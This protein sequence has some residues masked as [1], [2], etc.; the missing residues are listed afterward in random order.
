M[1]APNEANFGSTEGV[2]IKG[3]GTGPAQTVLN[4]VIESFP[5]NVIFENLT[6]SGK[7]HSSPVYYTDSDKSI[8]FRKCVFITG[9]SPWFKTAVYSL[10]GRL[11][12]IDSTIINDSTTAAD[13]DI[14]IWVDSGKSHRMGLMRSKIINFPIGL[15]GGSWEKDEQRDSIQVHKTKLSTNQVECCVE[16]DYVNSVRTCVDAS[17]PLQNQNLNTPAGSVSIRENI[18]LVGEYDYT[19]DRY[20]PFKIYFPEVLTKGHTFTYKLFSAHPALPAHN[21]NQ[22]HPGNAEP[23]YFQFDSSAKL[24][25]KKVKIMFEKSVIDSKFANSMN[26]KAFLSFN[27]EKW[28]KKPLKL[29]VVVQNGV[30]F[31]QARYPKRNYLKGLIAFGEIQNDD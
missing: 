26:I 9:V 7:Q 5:V 27:G 23:Q 20:L 19:T 12:F 10:S 6:F 4:T 1:N 31:Y 30:N 17:C 21:N 3:T 8:L 28:K 13:A 29:K 24:S 16:Y 2:L 22:Y 15:Y 18:D 11:T 25:T 14:G